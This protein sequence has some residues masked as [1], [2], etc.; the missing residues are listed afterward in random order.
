MTIERRS[1]RFSSRPEQA[2]LNLTG[3]SGKEMRLHAAGYAICHSDAAQAAWLQSD[4]SA[5]VGAGNWGDGGGFQFDSR[6]VAHAA[7]LPEARPAD[8]Y[9]NH[10]HRWADHGQSTRL[11]GAAVA[12]LAEERDLVPGSV[13]VWL[14][15][16]FPGSQ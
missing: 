13:R 3:K 2:L 5:D 6:C 10:T 4:C 7:T 14:D 1:I 9:S 8:A 12:G 15:I 11:G 16:Q